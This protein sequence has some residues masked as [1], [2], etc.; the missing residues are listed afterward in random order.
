M[1]NVFKAMIESITD[2][3][4][5][6]QILK[7]LISALDKAN[8]LFNMIQHGAVYWVSTH[9]STIKYFLYNQA[10]INVIV[11]LKTYCID[12]VV[13]C[14]VVE[15]YFTIMSCNNDFC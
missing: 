14:N 15:L 3:S 5:S 1:L 8:Y 4:D 9:S 13:I 10:L 6:V 12:A 7:M 2:F 11:C